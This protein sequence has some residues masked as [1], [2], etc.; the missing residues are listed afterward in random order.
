MTGGTDS[1]GSL[2]RTWFMDFLFESDTEEEVSILTCA[3][4]KLTHSTAI[5]LIVTK[6]NLNNYRRVRMDSRNYEDTSNK[7]ETSERILQRSFKSGKFESSMMNED[8]YDL[9]RSSADSRL[10][11]RTQRHCPNWH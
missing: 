11:T 8:Y 3:I 4:L 1:Y 9:P 2:L 7:E 6:V 10:N 5:T